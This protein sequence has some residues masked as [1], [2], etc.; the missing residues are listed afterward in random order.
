[1]VGTNLESWSLEEMTPFAKCS[2]YCEEFATKVFIHGKTEFA[3]VRY[4]FKMVIRAGQP[5][6]GLAMVTLY[7][8]R[9]ESL[10]ATS[11]GTLWS[12]IPG[13]A[14]AVIDVTTIQAVVGMVPHRS[15]GVNPL[16]DAQVAGRVYVAEKMGLDI[17][18]MA[19]LT[20]DALKDS[21]N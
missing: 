5:A 11:H 12:C 13:S 18:Q 21:D 15:I 1:M 16:V 10:F 19:G 2:D 9:D 3:E 20:D 14:L 4:F 8:P 6:R 7:G 17:T